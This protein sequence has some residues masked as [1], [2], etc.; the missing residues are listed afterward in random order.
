MLDRFEVN[1]PGIPGGANHWF[2]SPGQARRAALAAARQL[3][4]EYGI[5]HDPRP[6]RGLPH[7]HLAYPDGR[8][9]ERRHPAYSHFFYGRRPPRR[10]IRH[11]PWRES[12]YEL[13]GQRE[14]EPIERP[15]VRIRYI[16]GPFR[17]SEMEAFDPTPPPAGTTIL[18][19]FAFGR[20]TI[21]ARHR[22]AISRFAGSV[23]AAMPGTHPV[24]TIIIEVEG[25]EDEVGDPV[26]FGQVGS[27]RAQAVASTLA[28]QISE[29]MMRIPVA[30]RRNVEI[31]VSSAGPVR[32]IRSNVTREGRAMNRRVE[33]RMRV[34][35][36]T[37]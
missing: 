37:I 31:E 35:N 2:P 9:L 4:L 22:A 24:M 18:T 10:I 17:E 1:I 14:Y 12:E 21:S 3:G 15:R 25:H 27:Q 13:E 23:I 11:R 33:L 29:R 16:R 34:E 6:R 20:P 36:R 26:H 30:D 19:H 8:P 28:T 5:S 7:Y 32:P